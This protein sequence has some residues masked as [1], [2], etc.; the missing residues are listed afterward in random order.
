[1]F[2][3]VCLAT[4]LGTSC[5]NGSTPML[6]P[7]HGPLCCRAVNPALGFNPL[8]AAAA[9]AAATNPLLNPMAMASLGALQGQLA[10]HQAGALAAGLM[11]NP[12]AHL[13]TA[14]GLGAGAMNGCVDWLVSHPAVCA[15]MAGYM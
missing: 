12:A 5:D 10:G 14:A 9:A 7:T 15:A 2:V 13:A 4:Y 8:A 11:G 6:A 1:V 3:T